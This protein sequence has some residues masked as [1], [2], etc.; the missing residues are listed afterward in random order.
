M[1]IFGVQPKYSAHTDTHTQFTSQEG[2]LIPYPF[3]FL[4]S[5]LFYLPMMSRQ[6]FFLSKFIKLSQFEAQGQY[7]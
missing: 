7:F 3:I 4:F 6:Q 5:P 2:K 1:T